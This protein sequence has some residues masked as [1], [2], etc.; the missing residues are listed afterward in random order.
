M[1]RGAEPTGGNKADS[2]RRLCELAESHKRPN[3]APK[4]S[5]VSMRLFRKRENAA[6]IEAG[7]AFHITRADWSYI[8]DA[9]YIRKVKNLGWS[10]QGTTSGVTRN[11]QHAMKDRDGKP[12][13]D[14]FKKPGRYWADMKNEAYRKWYVDRLV[15]WVRAGADSIQ[16]DEPTTCKRTPIPVAA[17]FFQD[18][19]ERFRERIGERVPMSCNLAWNRSRFGGRGHPVAKQFDFGMAE[20]YRKYLKPE[21]L[22]SAARDAE[23]RGKA[24]I[25]TGGAHMSRREIRLAIAGCYANGMNYIV[26]WDQFT[27]VGKPRLFGKPEDFADL[28]GFVRAVPEYLDGCE[29]AASWIPVA[30]RAKNVRH[31]LANELFAGRA[32]TVVMVS[33]AKG[34]GFG[35][36]GNAA[37]GNGGIPR[38]YLMR[39]RFSYNVLDGPRAGSK[40]GEPEITTF[41]HDGKNRITIYRNGEPAGSRADEDHAVKGAFGGG[42]LLSVPFQGGNRNHPG[43]L[44]ELLA[45]RSE[46]PADRLG[47]LHAALKRK[48]LADGTKTPQIPDTLLGPR[49]VLHLSAETLAETHKQG[50]AVHRWPARTGHAAIV[51]QAR[52]P[53]GKRAAA[54]TFRPGGVNGRPAVRF[55]GVDD[56]V[57]IVA[58][59]ASTD[60][61]PVS[62]AS[63]TGSGRLC[64]FARAKPG[65]NDAPVVLHLVEWGGRPKRATVVLRLEAFFGDRNLRAELLTPRP[66]DEAVHEKAEAHNDYSALVTPTEL[67][68]ARKG[69]AARV[70]VPALHPWGILV[71]SPAD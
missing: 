48:Y 1:T 32:F 35:V 8:L 61:A 69:G 47:A 50:Q 34:S 22:M 5:D 46:L 29:A 41:V 21:T 63:G 10:F 27:G 68:V 56:L 19:H 11:P 54:P 39:G 3:G 18:V 7:K 52:L 12:R 71:V 51:P 9:D 20:F 64:L 25:Y 65:Q 55:D 60:G 38:L 43:D 30:L 66:Y 49:L 53:G 40:P 36:G 15:A 44:A 28:Y 33:A 37:N 23:R 24:L 62:V 17:K 6:E 42:G 67:D 45:F 57:R 31:N 4:R 26:P 14:H 58:T 16:R 13:L 2:V 70:A 59:S